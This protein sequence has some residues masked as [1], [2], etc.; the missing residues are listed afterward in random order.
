[1]ALFKALYGRRCHSPIGWFEP[2][3][4]KL[5][6][7]DFVKYA[8]EKVKLIQER[9]STSQ[10]RQ[11]SYAD[12]K[13]RDVSFMVGE[14]LDERLGYEDESFAIVDRQDR[15]LRSKRIFVVKVQWR[16]QPVEE[17]TW[18]PRRTCGA[19]ICTYLALHV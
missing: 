11:N 16:D 10:S 15:Q 5:Y 19:D 2:D 8:L 13:A 4:A 7:T 17:V 9:L 12:Q 3:E 6:G 18:S 14:K 1:M